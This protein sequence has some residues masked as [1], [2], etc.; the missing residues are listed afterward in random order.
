MTHKSITPTMEKAMRSHAGPPI[1]KALPHPMK[2]PAPIEPPIAIN[3][4][5]RPFKERFS[6]DVSPSTGF[7]VSS[8]EE[9]AISR[10][11]KESKNLTTKLTF[12]FAGMVGGDPF[13]SRG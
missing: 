9:I 3:C 5:C 1:A 11:L 10:R 12:R 7:E 8:N 2:S 4:R 13:V 6:G